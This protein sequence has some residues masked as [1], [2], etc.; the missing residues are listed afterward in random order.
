MS[1]VQPAKGERRKNFDQQRLRSGGRAAQERERRNDTE[2][3]LLP[4]KVGLAQDVVQKLQGRAR[5][6][7]GGAER[8]PGRTELVR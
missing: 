8:L 7:E 6:A 1:A 5:P 2:K 4:E 3:Q